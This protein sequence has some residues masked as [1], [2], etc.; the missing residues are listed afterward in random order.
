MGGPARDPLLPHAYLQGG[1]VSGAM[2]V[3]RHVCDNSAFLSLPEASFLMKI[4]CELELEAKRK[5]G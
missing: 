5:N 4:S 1:G 3:W 2:R